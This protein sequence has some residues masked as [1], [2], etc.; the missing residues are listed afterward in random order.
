LRSITDSRRRAS[1][2][3][4]T[5]QPVYGAFPAQRVLGPL[6]TEHG[7]L[8]PAGE[9]PR[10]DSSARLRGFLRAAGIR[11]AVYGAWPTRAGGRAS[12]VRLVSPFTG[13]SPRSGY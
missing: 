11:P 5:R 3:G 10:Y 4:T 6:F 1:L 12:P 8:A 2:P 7:R 13:L 9:P